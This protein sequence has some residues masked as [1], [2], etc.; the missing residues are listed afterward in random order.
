M[1]D[2]MAAANGGD[3]K[4]LAP[5]LGHSGELLPEGPVLVLNILGK[6]WWVVTHLGRNE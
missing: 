1:E 5:E 3:S 4:V 2:D 6:H